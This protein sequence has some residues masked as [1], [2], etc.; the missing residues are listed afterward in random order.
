MDFKPM[1]IP[2]PPCWTGSVRAGRKMETDVLKDAGG[3]GKALKS[4]LKI[5]PQ[6]S[7]SVSLGLGSP[8]AQKHQNYSSLVRY[9]TFT[10]AA[11]VIL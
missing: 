6:T 10:S 8:G 7:S 9:M 11:T 5:V 1:F 2:I 4:M 3:A